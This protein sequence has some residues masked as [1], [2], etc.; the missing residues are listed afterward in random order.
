MANLSLK[1]TDPATGTTYNLVAVD[2]GDSTYSLRTAAVQATHD[3]LN[4]NANMQVGNADVAVGNAVPVKSGTGATFQLAAG[5]AHVGEIAI[6]GTEI[7]VTPTITAGAYSAKDAVGGL[8]TLT[9]AV[10]VAGGIGVIE[11]IMVKDLAMV[12]AELRLVL[13]DRTF[14]AMADDAPWDPSDADLANC[15]GFIRI[16][17]G[18]YESFTDNSVATVVS[19]QL[20]FQFKLVATTGTSLFGQ[21]YCIGTPTYISVA[22]LTIKFSIRFLN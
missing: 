14:T 6:A 10:R 19:G 18:D 16:G 5:E 15:L 21:L 13:F 17:A 12:N 3:D 4:L 1:V 2:N 8:L 20:P 22:D 7:A 9:N 11:K